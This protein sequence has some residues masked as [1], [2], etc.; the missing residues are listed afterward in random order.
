M[1]AF[2]SFMKV[3]VLTVGVL[4]GLFVVLLALPKSRLRAIVLQI[5]GLGLYAF[6]ALCALYIINPI[7]IIPDFIPILGQ[8]DDAAALIT[9]VFSGIIGTISMILGRKVPLDML[10]QSKKYHELD[11]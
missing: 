5:Y 3:L 7:D 4:I 11:E 9:A 8:V 2:F 1:E 6:T 10:S